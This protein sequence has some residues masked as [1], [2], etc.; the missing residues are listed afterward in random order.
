M[1]FD[2]SHSKLPV[3]LYGTSPA[4]EMK[5]HGRMQRRT[6]YCSVDMHA[7]RRYVCG[8]ERTF[9]EVQFYE[10]STIAFA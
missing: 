5:G 10:Q 4:Y 2:K 1:I 9:L 8:H 7:G 3:G 6:V